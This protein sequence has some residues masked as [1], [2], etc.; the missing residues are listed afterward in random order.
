[1]RTFFHLVRNTSRQPAQSHCF[2]PVS[3]SEA[4]CPFQNSLASGWPAHLAERPCFDLES[5]NLLRR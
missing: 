5:F 2:S 1:M 3:F 4:L